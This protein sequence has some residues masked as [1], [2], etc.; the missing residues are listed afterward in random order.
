MV[1]DHPVFGVGANEFSLVAPSYGLIDP[2]TGYTFEHPH[3]IVLTIAVEL[4]LVGL[5]ALL[6]LV[7][8]LLRVLWRA[9]ATAPADRAAAVAIAAAFTAVAVQG[10]VDY[11]LRSNVLVAVLA[12][13]AGCA[14]VLGQRGRASTAR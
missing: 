4:G 3:N 13:L 9:R 14:V 5:A 11:T 2:I 1:L 8:G 12:V 10:L 6:W 7:A